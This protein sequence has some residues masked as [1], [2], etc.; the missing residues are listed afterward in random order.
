MKNHKLLLVVGTSIL[1]AACGGGGSD[2]VPQGTQI[3]LTEMPEFLAERPSE[4]TV[5]ADGN[6]YKLSE[7]EIDLSEVDSL[8]CRNINFDSLSGID[9]FTGLETLSFDHVGVEGFDY[10]PISTVTWIKHISISHDANQA[11]T[12]DIFEGMSGLESLEL[13]GVTD[14]ATVELY[15]S[16]ALFNQLNTLTIN[17]SHISDLTFLADATQVKHLNLDDNEISDVSVLAGLP[18]LESLSLERNKIGFGIDK[19]KPLY[20]LTNLALDGNTEMPC[21]DVETLK[22]VLGPGVVEPSDNCATYLTWK[23]GDGNVSIDNA[24]EGNRFDRVLFLEDYNSDSIKLEISNKDLTLDFGDA[25]SLTLINYFLNDVSKVDFFEWNNTKKSLSTLKLELN[26][27]YKAN[28]E[29]GSMFGGAGN[30]ILVGGRGNDIISGLE[31]D[32]QIEGGLG[33]DILKGGDGLNTYIF[34][35]GD[36]NDIIEVTP[37][38]LSGKFLPSNDLLILKG[39]NSTNASSFLEK[40]DIIL[41][42][43]DDSIRFKDWMDDS[44]NGQPQ[45]IGTIQFEDVDKDG[46]DFILENGL[47]GSPEADYFWGTSKDDL[48]YGLDGNDTFKGQDG[49]DVFYGGEGDDK[50]WGDGGNDHLIGGPG[51]DEL[52]GDVDNKNIGDNMLE[53]GTGND[54]LQGGH[55]SDVYIYAKGDGGDIIREIRSFEPNDELEFHNITPEEITSVEKSDLDLIINIVDS[56]TIRI[57][58]W[59]PVNDRSSSAEFLT[60]IFKPIDGPEKEYDAVEFVNSRLNN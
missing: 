24:M 33:D 46:W 60:F 34:A 57:V 3:V 11:W 55:G 54:I 18:Q 4:C 35:A 56:G 20:N 31:G 43:G 39:I 29:G 36:G 30:D 2:P 9:K 38:Y 58:D 51:N 22:D 25:G 41:K 45:N 32:D 53:G 48:V 16:I 1:L 50:L 19:L 7:F 23:M 37:D 14:K 5:S 42:I 17:Y 21:F 27:T 59:F 40:G 49:D 44:Q 12:L 47:D 8:N 10:S 6:E 15:D 52:Y 28:D 26:I 13:R